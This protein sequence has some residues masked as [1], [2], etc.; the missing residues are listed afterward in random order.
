L[1]NKAFINLRI[2]GQELN[3]GKITEQLGISP[4][5][6]YRKGE[7]FFDEKR[8]GEKIVCQEDCWLAGTE[9][10]PGE[11]M[12]QALSRFIGDL[13]PFADFLKRL[14]KNVDITIWASVYPES[15]QVNFHLSAEIIA[16]LHQIGAGFD[17]S[18]LFLRQFYDGRA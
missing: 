16:A 17:G 13:L 11:T 7:T 4:A 2:S 6:S 8:G 1:T 3:L 9:T 12:G 18:A 5:H 10:E 14:S 15:E